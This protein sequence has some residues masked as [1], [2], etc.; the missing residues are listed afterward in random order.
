MIIELSLDNEEIVADFGEITEV[1]SNHLPWYEGQYEVQPKK[2]EQ[3]LETENKSMI[4]N[5]KI[6]P[7]SYSSVDNVFGGQTVTIGSE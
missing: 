5:V 7:I 3:V 2:T 4:A 1:N 6:N